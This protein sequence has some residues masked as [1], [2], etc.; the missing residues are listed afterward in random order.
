MHTSLSTKQTVRTGCV[1]Q[2]KSVLQAFLALLFAGHT[3]RHP[4]PGSGDAG[5]Q[6]AL[7]CKALPHITNPAL[8]A[9][10][11]PPQSLKSSKA[12]KDKSHRKDR[13]RKAQAGEQL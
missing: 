7:A 1:A 10:T 12:K 11:Q 3:Q 2:F 5:A 9:D 13:K 4:A 6:A 8:I